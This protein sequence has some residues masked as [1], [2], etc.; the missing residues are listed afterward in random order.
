MKTIVCILA[1]FLWG[2]KKPPVEIIYTIYVQ[3]NSNK[4]VYHQEVDIYPNPTIP[5]K[6]QGVGG[7]LPGAVAMYDS[8]VPWREVIEKFPSDTISIILFDPDTVKF[9]G[10]ETV[11][12]EHMVLKR[13]DV[14]ADYL[15]ERNWTFVYPE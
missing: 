4:L 5:D 2:C 6:P 13:W 11:R 1:L 9:Y 7:I 15:E 8:R 3:N 12:K 10:W 14:D